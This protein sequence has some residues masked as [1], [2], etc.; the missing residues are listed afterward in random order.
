MVKIPMVMPNRE[1]MVR[2]LFVVNALA[3]EII[4]SLKI[5]KNIAWDCGLQMYHFYEIKEWQ[6][7][8]KKWAKKQTLLKKQS[9]INKVAFVLKSL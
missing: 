1:R 8:P 3:A 7:T 9:F 6:K 5:L 4:L 2:S